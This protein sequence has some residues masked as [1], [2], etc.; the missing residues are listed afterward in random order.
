MSI[1][2]FGALIF[3]SYS[4][5]SHDRVPIDHAFWFSLTFLVSE[6]SDEYIITSQGDL[7][8]CY[9][10]VRSKCL[11]SQKHKTIMQQVH[12]SVIQNR[13]PLAIFQKGNLLHTMRYDIITHSHRSRANR[14]DIIIRRG[15]DLHAAS[16]ATYLGSPPSY[17]VSSCHRFAYRSRSV[18]GARSH[19]CPAVSTSSAVKLDTYRYGCVKLPINVVDRLLRRWPPPDARV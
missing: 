10:R 9:R 18:R 17:R 15:S 7:A 12:I 16:N 13:R 11:K 14:T 19:R 3:T 4:R 1:G 2:F 6:I 5:Y 8:R